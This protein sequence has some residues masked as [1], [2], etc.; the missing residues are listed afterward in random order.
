MKENVLK[1]KDFIGTVQFSADD[2]VFFG[3]IEGVDD[4]ISF[5]GNSVTALRQSFEEA[6]DDYL[7]ICIELE[8]DPLKSFKGSFN[9][10]IPPDLHKKAYQAALEEGKSLNQFVQSAIDHE[11]RERE[12]KYNPC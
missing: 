4:L 9:V 7:Q 1:Y 3:R 12:S 8:K 2:E 5:E 6:V 10:R 11:V